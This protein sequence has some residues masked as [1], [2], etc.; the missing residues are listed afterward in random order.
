MAPFLAASISAA[1]GAMI[2]GPS[3]GRAGRFLTALA[4]LM[5]LVSFGPHKIVDPAFPQIWPA[6]VAAWVAVASLAVGLASAIAAART[7]RHP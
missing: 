6:V 1:T 3:G 5:A 4:I 2:L 7:R